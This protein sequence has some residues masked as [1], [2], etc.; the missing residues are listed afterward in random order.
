MSEFDK[1][2]G[3]VMN[4]DEIWDNDGFLSSCGRADAE[5]FYNEGVKTQQAKIDELKNK[6]IA[7]QNAF[8]KLNESYEDIVDELVSY[9]S[10]FGN[11][12]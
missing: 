8:D 4:F 11:R 3:D 6:V 12:L 10:R 2:V 5:H 7:Q 9:R 1:R